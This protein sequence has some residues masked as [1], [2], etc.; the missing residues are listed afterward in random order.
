MSIDGVSYS[1][2]LVRQVQ[3]L[4][5]P[6]CTNN[7]NTGNNLLSL[8]VYT[9]PLY[10]YQFVC[11]GVNTHTNTKTSA[12]IYVPPIYCFNILIFI[13]ILLLHIGFILPIYGL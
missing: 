12:I 6:I 11:V 10:T 7:K 4:R 9:F 3:C 1:R 13:L 8:Q 2:I 5:D